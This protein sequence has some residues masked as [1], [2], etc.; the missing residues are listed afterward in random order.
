MLNPKRNLWIFVFFW[1]VASLCSAEAALVS[2][3][4][5]LEGAQEYDEKAVFYKGEVIGDIMVRGESAWVNVRDE[6]GAIGVFCP[7]ELTEKIEHQGN[8]NFRGDSVS[9]R[10]EF[11]RA[12]SEHGGDSDI[13]AEKILI[14]EEGEEISHPLAPG[15][16]R[17]S[18]IL[19]AIVLLLAYSSR[20]VLPF[21][22]QLMLLRLYC[23]Q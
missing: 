23:R 8:Y 1:L 10:G 13:H 5:L 4:E 7:L 20:L 22:S 14:V 16:A 6:H 15:K 2:S 3:K 21:Y 12:C 19:P 9:V 11:H 17:A 18:A